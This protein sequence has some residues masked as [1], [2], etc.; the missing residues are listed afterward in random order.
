[1]AR[2]GHACDT[3]YF[4]GQFGIFVTG[5]GGVDSLDSLASVEFYAAKADHW[6]VLVPMTMGRSYHSVSM[7]AGLPYV[8]GGETDKVERLNGT[9]WE[10]AGSLGLAREHHSA[11]TIPAGLLVCRPQDSQATMGEDT[12]PALPY[13]VP[14]FPTGE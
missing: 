14:Q 3:G 1:M 11:V 9:S 10:Q 7:V 5:G 8:S 4:E 2:F 6:R 12:E 13:S